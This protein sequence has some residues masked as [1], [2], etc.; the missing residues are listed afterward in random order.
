M[1]DVF[2]RRATLMHGLVAAIPGVRCPRP[3]GAF[4]VFPDIS[5]Y[6]GRRTHA[7]RQIDS[8]QDFAAALLE[9][10]HVAVVPGAD[11]GACAGHH[12]RLGFACAENLI[13]EGCARLG[14]WC[15]AFEG[16]LV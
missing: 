14:Q 11:F 2:A 12:V 8:S 9:E 16:A 6:L 10:A 4:Y 1:R 7:G 13:E 3:T 5:A 15:A